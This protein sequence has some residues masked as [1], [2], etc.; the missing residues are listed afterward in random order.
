MYSPALAKRM[1][2]PPCSPSSSTTSESSAAF[3]SSPKQDLPQVYQCDECQRQFNR[4]YTLHEHIKTHTG[5]K[6]YVCP[7]R[8]CAKRFSTTGNL[9]RHR[10]LHGFIKP[11]QCPVMNCPCEFPSEHKLEKHMKV[12]FGIPVRIC[13]VPG[14][15]KTFSTTGN[16]NRHMKNQHDKFESSL[17]EEQRSPMTT[18]SPTGVYELASYNQGFEMM[19]LGMAAKQ[20]TSDVSN[21]ELLDALACLWEDNH[22]HN[23]P[24]ELGL[25]DDIVLFHVASLE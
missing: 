16:L 5:E 18:S 25:L 11:L 1:D 19:M 23:I 6:P 9:A 2:T 13:L 17:A 10:R 12:H 21:A 14:C 4:K 22:Q 8:S 3:S 20:P 24:Q 7:V 15:G